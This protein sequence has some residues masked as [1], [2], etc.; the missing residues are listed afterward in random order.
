MKP[1][2]DGTMANR[3]ASRSAWRHALKIGSMYF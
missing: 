2:D 3:L 1:I